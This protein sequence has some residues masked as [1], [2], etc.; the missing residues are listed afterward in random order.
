MK[1]GKIALLRFPHADLRS[2]KLRPVL[3]IAPVPGSHQDWLVAMVSGQTEQAIPQ[4]D[5]II[6]REDSDFEASGLK[7]TSVIRMG[8]LA[9][10]E[11]GLL[12]GELGAVS[13]QRLQAVRGRMAEWVLGHRPGVD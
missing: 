3:L 8:R 9:V 4:F 10:V 1:A 2:G 11:Q 6:E 5:E 13:D 7:T 12:L